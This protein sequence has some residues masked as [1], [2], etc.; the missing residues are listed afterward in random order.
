MRIHRFDDFHTVD[1]AKS[2]LGKVFVH[3]YHHTTLKGIINECE[4]YTQDE[5]SCHAYKGRKTQRNKAMFLETG[6]LY[7]YFIYGMH[8][9]MNITT[10]GKNRGCAVLIRSLIPLKNKEIMIKN[11]KTDK[12]IANGPGKCCEAFQINTSHNG[13]NLFDKSAHIYLEDLGFIPKKMSQTQ[14]IGIK[15]SKDLLWRFIATF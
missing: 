3:N 10:E 9:C 12:N 4:A 1:I 7:V 8:Y 6:H 14:R 2:L 15:K 13:L 5:E 11:R